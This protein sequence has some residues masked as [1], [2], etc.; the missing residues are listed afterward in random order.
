K[1]ITGRLSSFASATGS[2]FSLI[3][4]DNASGNYVK[5]VQRIPVKIE[6]DKSNDAFKDLKPGM[7]VFVK[8]VL[9]Q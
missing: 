7:S 5:V 1:K 3:P 2:K 8:I 4:P 9:D 6:L